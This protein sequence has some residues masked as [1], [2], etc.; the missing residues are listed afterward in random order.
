MSAFWYRLRIICV[1]SVQIIYSY[2]DGC[3]LECCAV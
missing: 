2:E 1:Q 3:L